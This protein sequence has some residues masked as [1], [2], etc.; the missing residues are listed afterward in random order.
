MRRGGTS[1]RQREEGPRQPQRLGGVPSNGEEAWLRFLR[2]LPGRPELVVYDSDSPS[3]PPLPKAPVKAARISSGSA[4][5]ASSTRGK[6]ASRPYQPEMFAKAPVIRS[7]VV[8]F[9]RGRPAVGTT[10][11]ERWSVTIPSSR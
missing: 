11:T 3:V 8:T 4:A 7:S 2:A 9:G 5:P 1:R 6:S 10:T